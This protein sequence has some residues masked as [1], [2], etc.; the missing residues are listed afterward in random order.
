MPY[1]DEVVADDDAPMSEVDE[2]DEELDDMQDQ[3]E[4]AY[5]F[6][7]EEP[8]DPPQTPTDRKWW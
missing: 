6:R 5:N 2:E 8:Y 1:Y 4:H 3:F 7:F